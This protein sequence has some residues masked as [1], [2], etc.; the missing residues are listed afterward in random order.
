MPGASRTP[1]SIPEAARFQCMRVAGVLGV[2]TRPA[3]SSFPHRRFTAESILPSFVTQFTAIP[4]CIPA[5]SARRAGRSALSRRTVPQHPLDVRVTAIARDFGY[6]HAPDHLPSSPPTPMGRRSLAPGRTGRVHLATSAHVGL[7]PSSTLLRRSA[8]C[9]RRARRWRVCVA[10]RTG[11]S[12]WEIPPGIR[13]GSHTPNGWVVRR[14]PIALSLILVSSVRRSGSFTL[15]G[16][17]SPIV[18]PGPDSPAAPAGRR[19]SFHRF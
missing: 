19:Q 3:G 6:A 14:N 8:G 9:Q 13:A 1:A 10:Q 15:W 7:L 18:L 5:A 16:V 4:Y 12:P 2:K 17:L 11:P